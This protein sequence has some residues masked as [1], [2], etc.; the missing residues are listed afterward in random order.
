MRAELS[1]RKLDSKGVKA[2]LVSRLQNALDDERKAEMNE[3][4]PTDE[5]T[6]Q[7]GVLLMFINGLNFKNA[8][9]LYDILRRVQGSSRFSKAQR[10][11]KLIRISVG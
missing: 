3:Q 11:L 10:F 6:K 2:N 9:I 7:P 4:K 1:A 8:D 5:P